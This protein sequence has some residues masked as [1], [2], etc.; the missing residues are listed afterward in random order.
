MLVSRSQFTHQ[1]LA[2]IIPLRNAF[3]ALF[4]VSL[5]MLASPR[6]ILDNW[7]MVLLVALIIIASKF[8]I[9]TLIPRL[10]GYS[11]KTTLFV[12]A[13]LTQVGE[14]SFV[15]GQAGLETG[16]MSANLY[17]L[18][19]SS[20][21]ITI[22]FTPLALKLAEVTYNSLTTSR[23]LA[24]LTRLGSDK[25]LI[26]VKKR[27]SDHVIICGY[28]RSGTN[29][30]S[31]LEDYN[32]PYIVVDL[33]PHIITELR[34]QKI[35][36]IYGDAGN[37]RILSMAHIEKARVLALTCPDPMA[38]ITATSY[39]KRVNPDIDII[40]RLPETS[41]AERLRKLGVSEIIDP[42]FQASLECVRHILGYYEVATHEIEGIVCPFMK[43]R[44]GEIPPSR[45]NYQ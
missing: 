5:G 26:D 28:G 15:I 44:E 25:P 32:I 36:C 7:S 4:F 38:E 31:V 27:L 12:G 30:S 17:S 8:I 23:R 9:C 24:P 2:D 29:I 1:A 37:T 41:V 16:V 21:F 35:P 33:N 45:A 42:A 34:A 40:A 39:A 43:I 13:G 10:Y 20:A 3:A 18:I 22:L 19:L 11:L 14:F 6:F